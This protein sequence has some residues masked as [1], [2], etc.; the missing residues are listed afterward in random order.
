[1][2]VDFNRRKLIKTAMPASVAGAA[3]LAGFR[4]SPVYAQASVAVQNSTVVS[5]TKQAGTVHTFVTRNDGRTCMHLIEAPEG[6]I[7]VDSG[8][9]VEFSTELKAMAD[10]LGKPIS[11]VFLSHDHP[12][13]TSGLEVFSGA[14]IMTTQGVLDNLAAAP[15]PSPPNIAEAQTLEPGN[16]RIAGLS[17]DVTVYENAEAAEQIVLDIPEL[18][19]I[20]VQDLVYNNNIFFPGVD[21]PNWI[22]TLEMLRQSTEAETVLCGHGYPA[23]TGE[24][25]AAIDYLTELEELIAASSDLEDLRSRITER[26]PERQGAVYIDFMAGLFQ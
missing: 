4:A 3:V 15:W 12:D 23:P 10:S 17:L 11:A 24:L 16:M 21:R 20:V 7:I 6:L 5:V 14:P 8:D 18:G 9:G 25:T 22:R 2:S 13:H 19:T 26:W 1:M